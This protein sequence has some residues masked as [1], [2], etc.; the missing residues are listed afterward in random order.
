MCATSPYVRCATDHM[1]YF[2]CICIMH[3]SNIVTRKYVLM[4]SKGFHECQRPCSSSRH[5]YCP[6]RRI[7][8]VNRFCIHFD[9]LQHLSYP[10]V[11]TNSR[12]QFY[13]RVLTWISEF[14]VVLIFHGPHKSEGGTGPPTVMAVLPNDT[15]WETNQINSIMLYT[16]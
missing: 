9:W 15:E 12:G 8:A 1:I 16:I 13:Y 5:S 11:T 10:Q 4:H 2:N 7:T 14:E 6:A 3:A